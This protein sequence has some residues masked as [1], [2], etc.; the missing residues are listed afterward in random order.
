MKHK[1]AVALI[2]TYTL[3]AGLM[4]TA[5]AQVRAVSTDYSASFRTFN[6]EKAFWLAEAGL[7][8]ARYAIANDDWSGWSV[9]GSTS[10]LTVSNS[11]GEYYVNAEKTGSTYQLYATAY[12]D[13][14]AGK[15]TFSKELGQEASK[16]SPFHFAAFGKYSFLM[17]GSAAT[18]SYDSE[19]GQYN[20]SGNIGSE[21]DVGTNATVLTLSGN[22]MV[23]GDVSVGIG[24]VIVEN[25]TG[26]PT[27]VFY[28]GEAKTGCNQ[29]M[30][31]VSVPE[32]LTNESS[33]GNFRQTWSTR[34]LTIGG[35]L[36][37]DNFTVGS[38]HVLN[39]TDGTKLYVSG[40]FTVNGAATLNILGDVEIYVD[41]TINI[42]GSGIVNVTQ[43]PPNLKV[44]GTSTDSRQQRIT[45]SGD[46]D[47]YGSIYAPEAEINVP[48][49]AEV[50]GSII[51]GDV[52]LTGDGD[53]HYDEALS[54]EI[55][56][57]YSYEFSSWEEI[58]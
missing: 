32:E 20:S 5:S 38:D 56:D 19:L 23:N 39:L 31:V 4:V 1:K 24:G 25:G 40:N 41:G 52:S 36:H 3:I 46:S 42:A 22:P 11:Y 15:Y 12:V 49:S 58:K 14:L 18:D 55:L 35:T 57:D 34:D 53:L 29:D 37:Y 6:N 43:R 47:F 8:K 33:G 13:G 2:L 9:S 45:I 50:Y 48:G 54:R 27:G 30:P 16:G 7:A 44:F 28:S 17:N 10:K 21:G 51:G 26:G